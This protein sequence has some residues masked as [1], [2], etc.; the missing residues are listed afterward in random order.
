MK[1]QSVNSHSRIW[2]A[3]HLGT[4]SLLLTLFISSLVFAFRAEQGQ[5]LLAFMFVLIS[6]SMILIFFQSRIMALKAQDRAIRAEEALRYFQLTGKAF[7]P[8]LR[9]QQIIALRFASDA[10][11]PALVAKATAEKMGNKRIKQAIQ[12]WRADHYRV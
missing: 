10:E 3:Y 5:G 6:V 1:P 11:F 7:D 4:F 2:P 12:Q 9:I 8:S